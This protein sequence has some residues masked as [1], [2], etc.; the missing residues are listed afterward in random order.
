[1]WPPGPKLYGDKVNVSPWYMYWLLA[2]E[3]YDF[4]SVWFSGKRLSF[5]NTSVNQQSQYTIRNLISKLAPNWLTID[6][7]LFWDRQLAFCKRDLN[8]RPNLSF[9]HLKMIKVCTLTWFLSHFF[10]FLLWIIVENAPGGRIFARFYRPRGGGFELFLPGGGNSTI[11]K[12][13][14]GMVR[15]G[16][17]WY[18]KTFTY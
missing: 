7:T 5:W 17:D 9:N 16:I 3:K 12:I 18:I 14:R 13:A 8:L 11:K 1:M 10:V 6:V 4:L 2:V 15:L